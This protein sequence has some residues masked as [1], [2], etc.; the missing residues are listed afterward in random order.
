MRGE[1][2]HPPR[3]G[4]VPSEGPLSPGPRREFRLD[5]QRARFNPYVDRIQEEGDL[6]LLG[7]QAQAL[8]GRWGDGAFPTPGPVHLEIGPGNGF[9]LCDMAGLHPEK[10]FVGVEIRYKRCWL[11]ARKLRV[12]GRT[13]VRVVHHHAGFLPDL[14]APE[15]LSGIY[16][17]HPDPWPKEKQHKHR[18]LNREFARIAT[19]LLKPSG[20]V[21]IKSDFAPYLP[22]IRE[23]FAEAPGMVE[24]AYTADVNRRDDPLAVGDVLTNYQ[25]KFIARG[26]PVF[27]LVLKKQGNHSITP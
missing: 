13:N 16:I 27:L 12:A 4:E 2:S 26:H 3:E 6:I 19:S 1:P 25:R 20:E 14:F 23:A 11:C 21:R 9:F 5:P 15:E 10:R 24:V 7:E 17:N 18:L 22:V 8:R